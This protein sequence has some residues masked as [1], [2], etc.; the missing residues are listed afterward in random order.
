MHFA[1]NHL[2][3]FGL[4]TLLRPSMAHESR[5]IMVSSRAHARIHAARDLI[6]T[7]ALTAPKANS[8]V[9]SLPFNALDAY[10]RSK[11]CNVLFAKQFSKQQ[12]SDEKTMKSIKAV[13]LHPCTMVHTRLGRDSR[14]WRF[15][16]AVLRPFVKTVSQAAAQTIQ[17]AAMPWS[18]LRDGAYY[19]DLHEAQPSAVALNDSLALELWR[20]SA[21]LWA[22]AAA[23]AT[24]NNNKND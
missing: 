1:V 2:G 9:S 6:T 15:L 20:Y 5:V 16:L 22:A 13:S 4:A 10:G 18:E 21:K 17:C 11:L 19:S 24:A 7:G 12:S 8:S 3:H 23:A 14:W